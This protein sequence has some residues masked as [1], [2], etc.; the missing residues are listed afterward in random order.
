MLPLDSVKKIKSKIFENL[1]EFSWTL[2]F[3]G[4]AK[5]LLGLYSSF[6]IA[7]IS[8]DIDMVN[9]DFSPKYKPET[10]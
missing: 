9:S 3:L 5:K 1:L 7:S 10:I 8:P 2:P 6:F 4:Y